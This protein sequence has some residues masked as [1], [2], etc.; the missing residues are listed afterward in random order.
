MTFVLKEDGKVYE[1]KTA[2]EWKEESYSPVF[3][4]RAFKSLTA[5][6]DSY[7]SD[8]VVCVLATEKDAEEFKARNR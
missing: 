7:H 1:C 5:F 8:E 4:H 3:G 6:H 2:R